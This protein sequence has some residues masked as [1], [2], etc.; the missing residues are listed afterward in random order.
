LK[1]QGFSEA[2]LGTL[3]LEDFLSKRINHQSLLYINIEEDSFLSEDFPP[4]FA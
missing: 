3:I 2:L 4:I 1:D